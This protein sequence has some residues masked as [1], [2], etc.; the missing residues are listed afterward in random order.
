M[1]YPRG[2]F[3]MTCTCSPSPQHSLMALSAVSRRLPS[4][5]WRQVAV[6]R[7]QMKES[8]Y[9]NGRGGGNQ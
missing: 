6:G 2:A 9:L 5:P 1:K 7:S 8:P 3:P 4:L